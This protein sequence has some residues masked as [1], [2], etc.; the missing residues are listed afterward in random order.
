[1]KVTLRIDQ[2]IIGYWGVGFND[3][4]EDNVLKNAFWNDENNKVK[5]AL[6]MNE[7]YQSN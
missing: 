6:V 5:Y 7:Q 1:M 3:A 4:Q 2:C